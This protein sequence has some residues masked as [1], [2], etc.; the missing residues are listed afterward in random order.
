MPFHL[1]AYSA[2]HLEEDEAV[3]DITISPGVPV[4]PFRAVVPVVG[5][6]GIEDA[7]WILGDQGPSISHNSVLLPLKRNRSSVPLQDL[8][9]DREVISW[10]VT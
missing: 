1:K 9:N 3:S 7:G 4:V 8:Q 2:S 5:S 10:Q 6:L